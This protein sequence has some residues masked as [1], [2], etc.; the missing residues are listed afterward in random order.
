MLK[1]IEELDQLD[2]GQIM[3]VCYETN[4]KYGADRYGN[5]SPNLQLLYAE[6]DLYAYIEMFLADDGT[7]YA[8]WAPEGVYK[9]VLRVERYSDGLIITGLETCLTDRQKGYA[10]ALLNAV[11]LFLKEHFTGKVYSHIEKTNSASLRLHQK[12]GFTMVSDTATYIDGSFHSEA[13]T[14]CLII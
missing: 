1:I 13:Y 2:I 11:I 6:Q 9:A 8:V 3:T 5:L 12:V 14:Y 10:T 4:L 7:A